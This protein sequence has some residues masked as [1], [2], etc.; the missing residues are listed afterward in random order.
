MPKKTFSQTIENLRYG[1]LHDELTDALNTLT[2]AVTNTNKVGEL[3]LHIKLKPTN[4]SGQM[5][6]ID[7]IKLKLPKENKGTSIMFATPENN[8]QR[9]DPRQLTIEGL[10]T[11]D[12]ETGE[13]KRVG[14]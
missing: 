12:M 5:E 1:T 4:N 13:L 6:V 11:V 8:L 14:T 2:A 7:D 3:T 9:E 10:R